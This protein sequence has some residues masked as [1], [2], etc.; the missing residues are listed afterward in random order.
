MRTMILMLLLGIFA[1]PALAQFT[2]EAN[3]GTMVDNNIDNNYLHIVD[4]IA[5]G[6]INTGYGW[7]SDQTETGLS[8]TGGLSYYSQVIDRSFSTHQVNVDHEWRFGEEDASTLTTSAGFSSRLDRGDYTIYNH[9]IYN[10]SLQ[11]QHFFTET[12]KGEGTYA[13]NYVRFNELPAFNYL[14]HVVSTE[15]AAYFST[16]TTVIAHA[17]I[18]MK[19]YSTANFDSTMA[20]SGIG[21][22]RS[23][24][25]LSSPSVTQLIGMVRV[26]QSIFENTGLS[27]TAQYQWNIQT[28]SRYLVSAYGTIS[29]D[30]LFDDHY[31]YEGLQLSGMLTQVISSDIR[32]RFVGSIQNKLY[33]NLAAYDLADNL[34]SGQRSDTRT[35]VSLQFLKE[36]E[37]LGLTLNASY[38]YI[39]N[40]SNASFYDYTN[41]AFSIGLSVPF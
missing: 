32:L 8:Y 10:G 41:H 34:V 30:A 29:D 6:S 21:R 7:S 33:S 16:R 3:L 14:E 31:G 23:Q 9:Q 5:S 4:R 27:L 1:A 20:S 15:G 40:V 37:S 2:V 18:G 35:L 38:D 13:F 39:I 19:I 17:I 22:G 11:L 12:L 28:E 25:S 26:G 36:F 24:S